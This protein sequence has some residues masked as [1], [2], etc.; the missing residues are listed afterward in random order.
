MAD[1]YTLGI[2]AGMGPR[3]TAPFVE[4]VLNACEALYGAEDDLDYPHMIIY[5]LPTPFYPG[6]ELDD[7]RMVGALRQGIGTLVR[8]GV[9][10]I[11]VPC[12][13][14][15]LYYDAMCQ[16]SS[17]P[18]LNIITET[19][20]RLGPKPK[21][22]AILGTGLTLRN[23][24]Y[25]KK[26]TGKGKPI[27]WNPALQEQVDQLINSIKGM[28]VSEEALQKWRAIEAIL[29]GNAVSEVIIACT[30]LFFC[31]E[32][33]CDGLTIYDSSAILA[34][35]LVQK[36]LVNTQGRDSKH[37]KPLSEM[38]NEELWQLFPII[39][40]P[41]D[42]AW[43]GCYL[44]ERAVIEAA[45]GAARIARISH[46]GSTA[47]PGLLAKP[48][49]DILVEINADT[50][51]AKLITAMETAGYGYSPQPENPAPHLMFMKGYTTHGFEG[52]VY[53][54]H[55]R[56]RG[57]WDELYFRDY[58]ITH[59]EV[60]AEYGRLKAD[61]AQQYKHDRDG[62]THAKTDF[63]RRITGLARAAQG[64]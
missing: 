51:I 8:A 29:L 1:R 4:H 32:M 38:T 27:F 23:Q 44:T 61:L 54:V 31:A 50:D 48:T 57:D 6:R 37:N 41:H 12:N 42:P 25:Q 36:Y 64:K 40:Q 21:T 13:T 26:L 33:S 58:L 10:I 14:A 16:A 24:L 39:I 60:A 53:H 11:A 35:S 2:L 7:A 19:I 28:A 22:T 46:V 34:E 30:D 3:S 49:V 17:V 47:V 43:Q 52:Q 9:D 20:N 15:H 56:Y 18:V 55:V 5:S 62:Y 59:P 63:V 45:I